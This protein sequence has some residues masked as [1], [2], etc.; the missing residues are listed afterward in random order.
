[1]IQVPKLKN[2][3]KCVSF[4]LSVQTHIHRTES[5]DKLEAAIKTI[6]RL[7]TTTVEKQSIIVGTSNNLDSLS[8]IYEQVRSRGSVSVLRRMLINN[9]D[10][11]TTYFL[12]N[13]QA[14]A[15]G[16]VALIDRESESPLGGLRVRVQCQP[17]QQVID[18]LTYPSNPDRHQKDHE[19]DEL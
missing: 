13:K 2:T 9:L 7:S 16:A 15:A 11:N 4:H 10:G 6:F 3:P 12:L 14:A 5:S 19:S 18:W 17:I 8:I 1:M